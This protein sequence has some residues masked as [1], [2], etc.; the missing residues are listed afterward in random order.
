MKRTAYSD[1][2]TRSV[3]INMS[4]LIDCVFLLLIFF[5][6]TTVFVEETGVDIQKPR[7]VSAQEL[8][9]HSLMI[10]L[11][12]NGEIVY[13]GRRVNLNSVRGL[14]ARHVRDEDMPVII[15]ADADARTA[16]LVDLIDECKLAGARRVSVAATVE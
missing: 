3:E 14:V 2:G 5:I 1:D 7:A 16:P 11:T 15:L 10:A 8:E 4:P 13:G 12:A 9:K 6:V